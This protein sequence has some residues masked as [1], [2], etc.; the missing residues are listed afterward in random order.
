MTSRIAHKPYD[1]R[2]ITIKSW[3][4]WDEGNVLEPDKRWGRQLLEAVRDAVM[5]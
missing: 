1:N 5:V 3:N 2:V 4:E